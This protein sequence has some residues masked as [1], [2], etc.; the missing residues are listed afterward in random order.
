VLRQ[1]LLPRRVAAFSTPSWQWGR[2][3]PWAEDRNELTKHYKHWVYVAVSALA[4]EVSRYQLHCSWVNELGEPD[5]PLAYDHPLPESLRRPNPWDSLP[6]LL[7][8]IA[9]YL[10]LCG[11]AFV[12]IDRNVLGM[13]MGYWVVPSQWV[14]AVPSATAPVSRY[15][16]SGNGNPGEGIPV[17]AEDMIVIRHRHPRSKLDGFSPLMAGAGWINSEDAIETARASGFRQGIW[18]GMKLTF[19]ERWD[20][21]DE[22]LDRIA[23]KFESRYGGEEKFRKL[24]ALKAGQDMQPLTIKPFEMDYTESSQQ[25]RDMILGLWHVPKVLAGITEE[26][27]FSSF[28]GAL[29]VFCRLTVEPRMRKIAAAFTGQVAKQFDPDIVCWFGDVIPDDPT[30]KLEYVKAGMN[31]GYVKRDEYRG[32][33][34]NLPEWSDSPNDLV[35]LARNLIPSDGSIPPV[36]EKAAPPVAEPPA[37]V[38]AAADRDFAKAFAERR[39]NGHRS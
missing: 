12:L 10:D 38:A 2:N 15:M 7:Y 29:T 5:A 21:K 8:D 28:Q 32:K 22:D 35:H 1:R 26:V 37:E 39:F 3:A 25:L 14:H 4:T 18:P 34:L 33:F 13:P 36:K 11:I 16:I 27:N 23:E 17:P 6:D 20:P 24:V 19:D 31:Y 30:L 9:L